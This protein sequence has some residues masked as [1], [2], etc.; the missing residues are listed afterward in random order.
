MTYRVC[1]VIFSTNRLDYLIPTLEAQRNL[2]FEGCTV[3]KIFFDD[4]PRDRDDK[5][6]QEL[7]QSYGY[8]EVYLHQRNEGLSST[9]VEFWNLIRDRDYDY[10]WQQEDDVEI[11]EP[12]KVLDLIDLLTKDTMLGQVVL[13]RQAWYPDE[14]ETQA[15]D[16]DWFFKQYRY[17]RESLIFS[18]MASLYA[19]DKVRFDYS[20]WYY[21]RN[22]ADNLHN[23][24]WN[25]GMLGK[26]LWQH[27]GLV[28]GHLKTAQ[29][30]NLINHIGEYFV[31][32]RALPGEPNYDRFKAFDPDKKYYS[33]TGNFYDE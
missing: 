3:D 21:D 16:S 2:D 5:A 25:E 32:K 9:W 17:E 20:K 29:G 28:S 13:K 23:I 15:L 8:T 18:P 33:R 24:N 4:Y 30:Q 1:Q 26:A 7:V 10:V 27:F 6:L 31:G 22:P 19:I 11:L 12:I 14:P